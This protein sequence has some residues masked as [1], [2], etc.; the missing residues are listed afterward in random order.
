MGRLHNEEFKRE[1]V[2]VAPTSALQRR[3]VATLF[4]DCD[5]AKF[6]NAQC[7]FRVNH[8]QF[9]PAGSPAMYAIYE[10]ARR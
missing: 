10:L 4:Q 3:Q 7:P 5:P 8:Y 6:K 1:D 9:A 2:R